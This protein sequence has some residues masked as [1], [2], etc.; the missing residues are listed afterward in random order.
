MF[1]F[2]IYKIDRYFTE[3]QKWLVDMFN[4]DKDD[5]YIVIDG[6]NDKLWLLE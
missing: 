1:D 3:M 5:R 4:W 6:E 2:V